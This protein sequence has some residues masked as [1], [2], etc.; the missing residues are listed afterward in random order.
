[1]K[2][3]QRK[4]SRVRCIFASL[5]NKPVDLFELK[6]LLYKIMKCVILKTD[7]IEICFGGNLRY[8]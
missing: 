7:E 8:I 2:V 6:A 4:L 3:N 1:M 5:W